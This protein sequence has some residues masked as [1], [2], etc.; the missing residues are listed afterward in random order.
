MRIVDFG[1]LKGLKNSPCSFFNSRFL[2]FNNRLD[3]QKFKEDET[4]Q[5]LG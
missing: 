4:W 1:S 3:F 5:F 2:F